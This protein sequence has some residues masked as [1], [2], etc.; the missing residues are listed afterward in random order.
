[1][2]PAELNT[3]IGNIRSV[4]KTFR[5]C[6]TNFGDLQIVHGDHGEIYIES[7]DSVEVYRYSYVKEAR[8]AHPLSWDELIQHDRELIYEW[9]YQNAHL[10]DTFIWPEIVKG[11][12]ALTDVLIQVDPAIVPPSEHSHLLLNYVI[13]AENV[14]IYGLRSN[15]PSRLLDVYCRYGYPC[16]WC[17]EWDSGKLVIYRRPACS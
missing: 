14:A 15:F 10:W 2:S 1:M 4:V 13:I 12:L 6:I 11:Y 8:I 16:G 9:C 3:A 7:L 5:D 17:G